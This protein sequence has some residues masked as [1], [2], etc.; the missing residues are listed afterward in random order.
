MEDCPEDAM[1]LQRLALDMDWRIWDLQEDAAELARRCK[2]S[3]EAKE[4]LHAL[5][6]AASVG[7]YIMA[8][9]EKPMPGQLLID[10]GLGSL[11]HHQMP[12][13]QCR[14]T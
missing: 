6:L 9:T 8:L 2:L 7:G 1:R 12:D 14:K 11:C 3:Q 4:A 13:S 5:M 10:H